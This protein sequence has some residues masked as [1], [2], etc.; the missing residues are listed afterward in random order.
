MYQALSVWL[1]EAKMPN[2]AVLAAGGLYV[3]NEVLVAYLQAMYSDFKPYSHAPY[4]LAAVQYFHRRLQGN[5]KLAWAAV[6]TWKT[7]EPG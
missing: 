5:L 1:S 3:I 6:R 7:A 2:I 4:T